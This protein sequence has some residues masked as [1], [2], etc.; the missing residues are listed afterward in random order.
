MNERTWTVILIFLMLNLELALQIHLVSV[1]QNQLLVD[2]LACTKLV[3]IH[4][5]W[6]A[7]LSPVL[8]ARLRLDTL[9]MIVI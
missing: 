8:V 6:L 1:C 5:Y 9:M 2:G 7:Q 4:R 3:L